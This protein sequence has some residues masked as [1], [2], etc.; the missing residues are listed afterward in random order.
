MD[1]RLRELEILVCQTCESIYR[2]S[3]DNKLSED[4]Y[5]YFISNVAYKLISGIYQANEKK[6]RGEDK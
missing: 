1:D 3:Y 5:A 2:K 4:E 6:L